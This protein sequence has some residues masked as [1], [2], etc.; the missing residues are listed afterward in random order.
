MSRWRSSIGAG[1]AFGDGPFD[2][3]SGGVW[4][5]ATWAN[6]EDILIS[7]AILREELSEV[8]DFFLK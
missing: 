2:S 1:V 3:C 5:V 4:E 6:L 7:S 8:I